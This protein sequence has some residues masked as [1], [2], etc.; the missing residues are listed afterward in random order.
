MRSYINPRGKFHGEKSCTDAK[1]ERK[2]VPHVRAWR[3]VHC[4]KGRMCVRDGGLLYREMSLM[5]D[6]SGLDRGGIVTSLVR[7]SFSFFSPE[8]NGSDVNGFLCRKD[9]FGKLENVA[10]SFNTYFS[11]TDRSSRPK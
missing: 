10:V 1:G 4:Y 9:S 11:E 6:E 2:G 5:A 8:C 3:R 7:I